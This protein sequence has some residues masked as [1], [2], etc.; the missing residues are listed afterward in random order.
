MGQGTVQQLGIDA[1][2]KLGE[3][4]AGGEPGDDRLGDQEDK[5][6]RRAARG[7]YW[8]HDGQAT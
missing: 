6:C 2:P 5:T 3:K 1:H 7:P 4:V 8:P